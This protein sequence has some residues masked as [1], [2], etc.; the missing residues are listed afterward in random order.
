MPG[1]HSMHSPVVSLR[2]TVPPVVPSGHR[3]KTQW[4]VSSTVFPRGQ[5]HAPIISSP[6]MQGAGALQ[7]PS[8][9]S[10]RPGGQTAAMQ[11]P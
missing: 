2:K 6:S 7:L 3:A 5:M 11:L 1:R 4:P 9:P 8:L 10:T